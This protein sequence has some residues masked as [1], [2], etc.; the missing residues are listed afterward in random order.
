VA[1]DAINP[2]VPGPADPP[3]ANAPGRPAEGL[4]AS[5]L[6]PVAPARPTFDLTAP[7]GAGGATDAAVTGVSSA[8]FHGTEEATQ[9]DS[10]AAANS[11]QKKGIWRAW[12]LAGAARWGRGGGTQNKRLDMKKAKAQAQ[13]VKE[14]RTVSINRSPAPLSKGSFGAGSKGSS[15]KSLNSK[16]NSGGAVKGPQNSNGKAHQGPAGRSGNG[17]G[18]GPGGSGG[19]GPSGGRTTNGPGGRGD[20]ASPKSPKTDAGGRRTPKQ[21]KT[22]LTKGGTTNSPKDT[23]GGSAGGKKGAPGPAGSPGKSGGT[24]S[25]GSTGGS[26][27]SGSGWF[28]SSKNGKTP[29]AKDAPTSKDTKQAPAQGDKTAKGKD[30]KAAPTP[31]SAAT[32][33]AKTNGKT[34]V[35]LLKRKRQTPDMA[36]Q[37]SSPDTPANGKRFSTRESRETGYRDGTRAAKVAAHTKAY[38]DGVKDGWAD[39]TQAADQQKSRLDE[40]HQARIKARD[41]E[42][43]VTGI[44]TSADYH[45]PEPIGVKEVTTSHVVLGDGAARESLSRAEVRSL[46]GFERRLEA[47]TGTMTKIGEQTKSLKGHADEQA[48]KVTKL[49]E[50]AKAVKGGE[51]LAG[52][53][54]KLQEAAAVQAGKAEDIHKRAVRAAEGCGVALA[55]VETRYG[56]MY[57]AVVDSDET[58]PAEL[59]F[60]KDQG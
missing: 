60:Y 27:G 59:R 5:L 26:K 55:N 4:I 20:S 11:A 31:G 3:D 7:A 47:K 56:G 35:N 14:T 52:S 16:G 50:D 9:Q 41:E 29:A 30:T 28:S 21:E 51:K 1:S 40:A 34:K 37:K 39:T 17:A 12:M 45:Q 58:A 19:R 18:T 53:L 32:D 6:A 54:A 8:A 23:S 13:Q 49:L 48:K 10:K 43:P 57:K 2:A 36:G 46:K 33:P 42:K 15:N 22:S 44:E 24:G 25:G 38:R